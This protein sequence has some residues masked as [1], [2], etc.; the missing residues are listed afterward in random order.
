MPTAVNWFIPLCHR[1][2]DL[3]ILPKDVKTNSQCGRHHLATRNPVFLV[4][5]ENGEPGDYCSGVRP[6]G[7]VVLTN[8]STVAMRRPALTPVQLG[9]EPVTI[10]AVDRAHVLDDLTRARLGRALEE[11]CR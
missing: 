8:G 6:I 10:T 4:S 7:C 3:H 5:T 2:G 1:A 9:D 11:K